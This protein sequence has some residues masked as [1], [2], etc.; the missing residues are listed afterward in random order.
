VEEEVVL[1]SFRVEVP[2]A[3]AVVLPS[4]RVVVLAV[5]VALRSLHRV[6]P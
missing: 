1:P 6:E 3:A 5:A 2:L 4:F